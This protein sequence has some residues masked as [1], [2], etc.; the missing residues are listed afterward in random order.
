VGLKLL[1]NK[2]PVRVYIL[3]PA[4]KPVKDTLDQSKDMEE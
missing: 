3:P 2:G 1:M 4:A